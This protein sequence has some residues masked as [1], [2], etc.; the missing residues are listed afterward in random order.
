MGLS[1]NSTTTTKTQH[2]PR[3]SSPMQEVVHKEKQLPQQVGMEFDV[4]WS[5]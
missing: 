5:I 4:I 1:W 2:Q 3:Y